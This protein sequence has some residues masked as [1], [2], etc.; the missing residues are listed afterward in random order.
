[1]EIFYEIEGGLIL[2]EKKNNK[3]QKKVI[4]N[5]IESFLDSIDNLDNKIFLLDE[6]KFM[7][8]GFDVFVQK[9]TPFNIN[10]IK[11]IIDEKYEYILINYG[12]PGERIFYSIDDIFV[13]LEQKD[14][15]I[16]QKGKIH[17]KL[18]LFFLKKDFTYMF[19]KIIGSGKLDNTRFKI[20]PQ[21]FFTINYLKKIKSSKSI[22]LL[23][24]Y[25]NTIKLI[26]VKKGSYNKIEKLNMGMS[27]LKEMFQEDDIIRLYY[28]SFGNEEL[29]T[30]S[31]KLIERNMNFY[32]STICAWLLEHIGNIKDLIIIGD[33]L[34]NKHFLESFN[35]QFTDTIKGYV[36]P[37]NYSE[38]LEKYGKRWNYSDLDTLTFLNSRFSK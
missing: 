2:T 17:F 6:H 28:D 5:D 22:N 33:I 14:Y 27:K 1:M 16:G 7:N 10:E 20:Y 12:K 38:G 36:I 37:F 31:N 29:N 11:E 19:N 15:L 8:W 26:T 24:F 35:N 4:L 21:S 34:K 25:K 9:E 3:I 18:N 13:G 30:I 23:Y 32:S